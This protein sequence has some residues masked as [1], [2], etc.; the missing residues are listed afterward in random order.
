MA[1]FGIFSDEFIEAVT[2]AC[3]QA[4]Q[5]ALATGHP[6]VFVDEEG[7]Y[8]QEHPDGRKYEIRFDPTQPRESHLIVVREIVA[9]AA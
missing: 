4:R 5:D 1:D 9:N 8:V 2:Q 7:R 6:V 3:R